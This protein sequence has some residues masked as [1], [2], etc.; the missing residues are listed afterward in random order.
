MNMV[1]FTTFLCSE[2][3][4]LSYL[5]GAG[6]IFLAVII[7]S[8]YIYLVVGASRWIL[9]ALSMMW[10]IKVYSTPYPMYFDSL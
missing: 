3:L 1:K 5:K 8:F 2:Y 4:V 10:R 6:A 9:G 7:L